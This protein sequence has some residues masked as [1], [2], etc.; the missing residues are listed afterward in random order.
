MMKIQAVI[1]RFEGNIA[2]LLVGEKEQ[3]V[4]WP[5]AQLPDGAREGDVLDLTL[6]LNPEATKTKTEQA[7]QLIKKLQGKS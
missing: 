3:L 5:K 2:I 4:N 6:K 1:D 7:S